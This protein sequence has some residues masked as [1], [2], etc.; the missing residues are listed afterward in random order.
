MCPVAQERAARWVSAG[1]EANDLERNGG[2][3][4]GIPHV[5][6]TSYVR[7]AGTHRTQPIGEPTMSVHSRTGFRTIFISDLH[8]GTRRARA[9]EALDF[10]T[11]VECEHL[12]LVGDIT[13]NHALKR[14]W[15]W[16][17]EHGGVVSRLLEIAGGSTRVT[18]VPG[19]HDSEL[20]VFCGQRLAG[21]A[22]ARETVHETADGR[23]LLVIHG[24]EFD[25]AVMSTPWLAHLGGWLYEGAIAAN[26]AADR[27]LARFGLRRSLA[28]MLRNRSKRS[29]AFV[30]QFEEACVRAARQHGADGVVCGH[31]HRPDHRTID[32]VEYCNDGDWVDHA[33]ALVEHADGRLELIDWTRDRA[34]LLA[35]AP[36]SNVVPFPR[37]APDAPDR[38]RRRA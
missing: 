10:L 25:G 5:S 24:D 29:A 19:N 11:H 13:D 12:F 15:Y 7:G 14:R 28:T 3:F 31:L 26:I 21:V 35:E 20:R 38:K 22:V 37:P 36:A 27:T 16:K 17:P 30:R 18:Y 34:R 8:L 9:V 1:L 6:R 32:G 2:G 23:R 33:T 4:G